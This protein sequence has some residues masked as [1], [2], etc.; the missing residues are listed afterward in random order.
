MTGIAAEPHVQD[1]LRN[2]AIQ[3]LPPIMAAAIFKGGYKP[4]KD[5]AT[6]N[7]NVWRLHD[8]RGDPDEMRN[9]AASAPA[10]VQDPMQEV[11]F[12]NASNGVVHPQPGY[13]PL[14]QLWPVLAAALALPALCAWGL[15]RWLR[16]RR[17]LKARQ[18]A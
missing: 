3:F 2:T 12:Y 13:D 11:V 4:V 5:D 14:R 15:L 7:D 8:L 10:I 1:T 18:G 9:L 6:F 16:S 17:R